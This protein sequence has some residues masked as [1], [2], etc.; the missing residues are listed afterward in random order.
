MA[1]E[2]SESAA[3]VAS[4]SI[5]ERPT[6]AGDASADPSAKSTQTDAPSKGAPA[7][8]HHPTRRRKLLVGALGTL[9]LAAALI[10]GI[11]WVRQAL[12]TVS[13]DDAYVNGHVT[14]VAP[15]VP[16]QVLR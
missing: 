15:R 10:F 14:F 8:G 12:N 11:P 1:T 2:K 7:R 13:T 16:G 9:V 3:K 5:D 6:N 4:N